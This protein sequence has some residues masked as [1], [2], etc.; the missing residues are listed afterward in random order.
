MGVLRPR[1]DTSLS[2]IYRRYIKGLVT[3]DHA[4]LKLEITAAQVLELIE[5]MLAGVG[6]TD[7]L[8]VMN[9]QLGKNLSLC[10]F[11]SCSHQEFSTIFHSFCFFTVRYNPRAVYSG[12]KLATKFSIVDG[13]LLL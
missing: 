9:H 1:S 11:K 6:L 4:K 12:H 10:L 2:Y 5:E 7:D 3:C 13:S 8:G